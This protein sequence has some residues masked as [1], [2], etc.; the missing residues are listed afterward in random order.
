VAVT[1]AGE[2]AAYCIVWWDP[3]TRVGEF[4]PV[5]AAVAHRRQGYATALLREGLRRLRGLGATDAIVVSAT[6]PEGEA[7]RRLYASLGFGKVARFERW[8]KATG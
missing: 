7:A 1:P 6:G 3:E 8:E 5:G 4:E 2:L